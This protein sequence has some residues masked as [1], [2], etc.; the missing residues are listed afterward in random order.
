[1]LGK[2]FKHE[3]K[4]ISRLLLIVHGF[5]LIFALFSRI[6]L[7]INGGIDVAISNNGNNFVSLVA[8]LI[9]FFIVLFIFCAAMLTYIYIGY[10]F[11]KNVFTDQGYLTNTLPVTPR[12]IIFSKGLT[13]LLWIIIDVIVLSGSL[14]I[15]FTDTDLLAGLTEA[16]GNMSVSFSDIP[17][18]FWLLLFM[19]LLSPFLMIVHLYFCVSVGSLIPNHKVLGAVGT[20]I[21]SYIIMQIIST[22]VLSVSG[23]VFATGSMSTT[24]MTNAEATTYVTGMLNP[25][26]IISIIFELIC[27]VL[28]FFVTKYIMTKK[29]NLE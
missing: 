8:A 28:F 17:A 20:Y 16:F 22:V 21:I 10:R 26:F 11:Y 15:L 7:E 12:Q 27:L 18:F 25:I 14:A 3:W 29:L 9:I 1:M 2:L 23:F 4:S 19:L 24:G 5:I 13:G 6:F